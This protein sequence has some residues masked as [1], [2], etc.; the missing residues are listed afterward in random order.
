MNVPGLVYCDEKMIEAIKADDSLYQVTNVATLPGLVS[1]Q[2][3]GGH[4]ARRYSEVKG[5]QSCPSTA[6]RSGGWPKRKL[7]ALT[8]L[9]QNY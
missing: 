3:N 4:K 8:K 5:N 2:S 7:N 9:G 6:M 1:Q